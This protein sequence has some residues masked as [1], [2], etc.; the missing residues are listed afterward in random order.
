MLPYMALNLAGFFFH[1]SA[2]VFLPLYFILNKQWPT[3]LIWTIFILGNVIF[4]M[5]IKYLQPVTLAMA[6]MLGG[7]MAV[8]VRLYF[9]SDY[10]SQAYGLGLGYI[11]RILTFLGVILFQK[12]LKEQSSYNQIFI[13]C[14][15]LYFIIYFFFAEMMV[16]VE[17]LSLLFVFAYWI[18]YPELLFLINKT[19][20][21][22]L[23]LIIILGYSIL[24]IAQANSNIF[25]KY[26]NLLF[27]IESFED[28]SLKIYNNVDA[29]LKQDPEK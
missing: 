5:H 29:I 28:R 6:D 25:S 3:W 11:E 19:L 2:L 9:A 10:Y 15:L 4:L 26:D 16:A 8:K 13:N 17:R 7:R 24:K 23:L 12:K 14:Y 21:K 22:W 1:S 27:G 20:N 18:L